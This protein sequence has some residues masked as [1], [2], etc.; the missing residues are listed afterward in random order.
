MPCQTAATFVFFLIP[1]THKN[2]GYRGE[3]EEPD[4]YQGDSREVLLHD[5]RAGESA[6]HA[7][8]E[9]GREPPALA[10]VQQD[11]RHEGHAEDRVQ[12]RQHINHAVYSITVRATG[13]A[14]HVVHRTVH[15][16]GEGLYLAVA[17]VQDI[18]VELDVLGPEHMHRVTLEQERQPVHRRE[19]THHHD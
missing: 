16:H 8:A 3:G 10:G 7:A 19:V 18:A 12:E 14:A 13:S 1:L 2:Q 9:R 15:Q 6:P 11:Q 17:D 5:G 4:H